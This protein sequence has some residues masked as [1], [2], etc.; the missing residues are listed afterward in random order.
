MNSEN[1]HSLLESLTPFL[2]G[3][4]L[5]RV[6]SSSVEDLRPCLLV[7]KTISAAVEDNRVFQNLNLRPLARNPLLTFFQA[8]NRLQR[9][10]DGDNPVAHF[11]EGIKQYFVFD[12]MDLGLFH[13]KKSAEGKYDSGTYLYAMLLLC[14]GNFAEGL[15]VLSS[16]DW[17]ESKLRADRAWKDVKRS[18]RFVFGIM[19]DEYIENLKNNRP[20]LSCHRNDINNRCGRCFPYKQMR[21]FLAFIR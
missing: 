5:S 18:M 16:L 15:T 11:I 20:P 13:L 17:E 4:I 3:D 14:T 10:L 21:R 7:S 12:D 8:R 1:N 9:C 6:G 2:L 19:K